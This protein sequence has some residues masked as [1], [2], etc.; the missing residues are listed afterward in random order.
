MR[1]MLLTMLPVAIIAAPAAAQTGQ[2][3][4]DREWTV[5]LSGGATTIAGDS[6]QPFASI[7]LTRHWGDSYVR[8]SGTY[9][10]SGGDAAALTTVPASTRQL[11]LGAGT[12]AGALAIDGYV[13]LGDRNF[14]ARAYTTRTGRTITLDSGGSSLGA[15]LSLTYEVPIGDSGVFAPFVA[16]DYSRISIARALLLPGGTSLAEESSEK[17]VTGSAGF[18]ALWLL[19]SEQRHSIGLYGAA[20]ASSNNSSYNGTNAQRAT[21]L[22]IGDQPGVSDE[23]LEYGAI[24]S[25]GMS[26]TASLNLGIVRTAGFLG[27]EATSFTGGLSFSF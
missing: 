26:D 24:A 10:D 19:G 14:D 12:L 22:G 1:K 20:L 6:D 23:W 11:T 18:T 13:S 25:I 7:G 21:A 2:G 15:G 9:V 17:G 27:P 16:G 4:G 3:D 5:S 8:L